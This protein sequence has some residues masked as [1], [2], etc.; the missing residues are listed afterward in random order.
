MKQNDKYKGLVQ[1]KYF[2]IIDLTDLVAADS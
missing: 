1:S 2:V